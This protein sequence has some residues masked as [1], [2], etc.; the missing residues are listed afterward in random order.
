MPKY[1]QDQLYALEEQTRRVLVHT[2][3]SIETNSNRLRPVERG[4]KIDMA[5]KKIR[6]YGRKADRLSQLLLRIWSAIDA[7]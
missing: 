3:N 1:T 5:T 6:H 2:R 4:L 7:S